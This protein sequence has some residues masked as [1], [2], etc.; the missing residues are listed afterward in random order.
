MFDQTEAGGTLRLTCGAF[1]SGKTYLTV[2]DVEAA[3]KSGIYRKIYSNIRGHATLCEGITPMPDDWRDC[4]P[5]SLI[6]IDEV[7]SYEKFSLYFSKRKDEEIVDITMMRHNHHDI[8]MTSPD[9]GWVNIAIRKLVNNYIYLEATGKKTSKAWCFTRAQNQ[10]SKSTKQTCYDEF[11]F[12]IEDKY[13]SLYMSTKDG[14]SSGRAFHRNIKLI[15]FVAG[16]IFILFIA[17]L[18]VGYL[19]K[20]TK[21]NAD[22]IITKSHETT[23]SKE[24]GNPMLKANPVSPDDCRKGEN[25]D[26][27]ECIDFYNN[28]GSIPAVYVTYN[29]NKPYESKLPD[30]YQVKVASFPKISGAMTMGNGHCRAIDQRGNVMD[31]ISQTDCKKW[32]SGHIPFDY[33]VADASVSTINAAQAFTSSLE[34]KPS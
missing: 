30:D 6:I 17:T 1:G 19:M 8:W 27:Q 11:I 3:K 32:L 15:G 13:S 34:E 23:Q 2:K 16:L 29:P 22:K 12:T 5:Y 21:K 14:Q 4:E 24:A 9:P 25:V 28:A 26:K 7:Q 20:D 31:D 33:S 10:V 18:L